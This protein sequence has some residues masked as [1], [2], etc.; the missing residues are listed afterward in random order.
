[1]TKDDSMTFRFSAA[2]V[3]A[4]LVA[5]LS[6]ADAQG[7]RSQSDEDA[8]TPDVFRLCASQIPDET[9]IVACLNANLVNLSPACHTVMAP[10]PAQARKHRPK[11]V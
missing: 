6:T 8:C 11:R 9:A 4:S 10:P 1:M 3:A 2:L 7:S 5:Q